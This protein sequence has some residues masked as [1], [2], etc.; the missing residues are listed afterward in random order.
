MQSANRKMQNATVL[1]E[2][3]ESLY[4]LKLVKRAGLIADEDLQPL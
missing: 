4:W 3:R 1:K 2:L